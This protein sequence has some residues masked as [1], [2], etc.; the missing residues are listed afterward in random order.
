[1]NDGVLRMVV[2]GR[3]PGK[4]HEEADGLA[5]CPHKGDDRRV[6]VDVAGEIL[7]E[8]QAILL[9]HQVGRAVGPA[10]L[11]VVGDPTFVA[12]VPRHAHRNGS[13]PSPAHRLQEATEKGMPFLGEFRL[14]YLGVRVGNA[15]SY[16]LH[17][18]QHIAVVV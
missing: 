12:D 9:A 11:A 4:L 13:R 18:E 7:A 6:V 15:I 17:R 2:C 1:M 14:R 16:A 8:K 10:P 3:V 5:V